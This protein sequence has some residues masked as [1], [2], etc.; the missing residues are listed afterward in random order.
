MWELLRTVA[1]STVSAL[2]SHRDLA[3]ENLALRHQLTV[4]KRQ[5]KMPKLEAPDRLFWIAMK[6]GSTRFAKTL[7]I[8]TNASN[9]M[10][11]VTTIRSEPRI[12]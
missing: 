8:S 7:E 5:S 6:R 4:L 9:P 1:R 3:L 10:T 11:T 2:G 12:S